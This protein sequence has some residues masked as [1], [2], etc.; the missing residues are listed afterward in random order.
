MSAQATVC[1]L[2][3]HL[4]QPHLKAPGKFDSKGNT[5]CSSPG[6]KGSNTTPT[7]ISLDPAKSVFPLSLIHPGPALQL[8]VAGEKVF[9][10]HWFPY[11]AIKKPPRCRGCMVSNF[12]QLLEQRFLN[13]D[14]SLLPWNT[15]CL[16]HSGLAI[17]ATVCSASE[18]CYTSYSG[19]SSFRCD[20][21]PKALKE[22]LVPGFEYSK[23]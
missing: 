13:S 23:A 1:P 21:S 7:L 2:H 19:V 5:N 20:C 18:C 14:P 6:Q 11:M 17:L 9:N 22:N 10:C 15:G 12:Q 16:L 8:N 4:F 3:K